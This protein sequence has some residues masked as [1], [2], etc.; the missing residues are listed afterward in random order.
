MRAKRAQSLRLHYA[1]S[2]RKTF[3]LVRMPTFENRVLLIVFRILCFTK[4]HFLQLQKRFIQKVQKFFRL[5]R[6]RPKSYTAEARSCGSRWN[7]LRFTLRFSAVQVL[8]Q[9]L[10]PGELEPQRRF[11]ENV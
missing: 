10:V 2:L 11:F 1:P 6:L 3:L 9:V 8:F 4:L 5:W 7:S